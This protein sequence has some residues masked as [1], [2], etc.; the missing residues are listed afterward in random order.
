MNRMKS[1]LIVVACGVLALLLGCGG[2]ADTIQSVQIS[3]PQGQGTAPNGAVGF[4]ATGTFKNNQSRLLTS[5]DGLTWTSSNT[6]VATINPLTGQAICLTEGS[7]IITASV[8]SDLVF[9]V[10]GHTS[11][12]TVSATAGLQCVVAG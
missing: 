1:V 7:A 11:S 3:P 10:G 6:T 5:Q 12:N 9:G 2:S 4:T 8:P